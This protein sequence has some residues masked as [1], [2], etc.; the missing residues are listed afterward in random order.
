[1]T[2]HRATFTVDLTPGEPVPGAAGRFELS[3]TW[4]GG[5]AG[6]SRGVMLTAGD[7]ATGSASYVASELFEGTLDGR[8]GTLALQQLG[9]MAGGD[10]E[11]QYV[12]APGSGTGELAGL[13]GT[14]LIGTID[15]DGTHHVTIEL[16]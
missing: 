5:A 3:K 14:L 15:E 7:P 13:T 11:L 16:D 2:T 10:P 12:I 9:T 6:T 8:E 4:G 1:M